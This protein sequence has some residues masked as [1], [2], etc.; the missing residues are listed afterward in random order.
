[1]QETAFIFLY[2]EDVDT[3]D[4]DDAV[5]NVDAELDVDAVQRKTL[6]QKM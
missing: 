5:D 4:E 6:L 2:L 3:L 1:M